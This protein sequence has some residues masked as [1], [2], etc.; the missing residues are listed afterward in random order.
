MDHSQDH[1]TDT[2]YSPDRWAFDDQVTQVFDDML[3]RSIPQLDVMRRACYDLA[4]RFRM[5]H[6]DI[7]DL[8]ASRGASIAPLVDLWGMTNSFVLVE[9]SPPMLDVLR[10][11]FGGFVDGPSPCVRIKDLDL[12]KDFPPCMA[13]VIQSIL[14]MMFVP[15]ECRQQ[16]VQDVYDSLQDGG[17]FI[18]VEKV[19]GATA[20]VNGL[21]VDL[22]H[23]FKAQNGYSQDDIERKRLAL[24]GV[25]VPVTAAWN[26]QL[27][28][29]AGFRAVDCFWRWMN[30]CGWVAIK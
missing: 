13:S 30:F 8:G 4:V 3:A 24:S 12:A 16:L 29:Q 25:L 28:T 20:Q 15:L 5:P 1:P 10:D 2:G 23:G 14:T 27:L 26:E 7:V 11:R 21:M 6:T 19:L 9:T 17:A 18:L 22:Y